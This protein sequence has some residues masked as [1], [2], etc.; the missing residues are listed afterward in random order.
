LA[1]L[2]TIIQIIGKARK[3]NKITKGLYNELMF[4]A[5]KLYKLLEEAE[6]LASPSQELSRDYFDI[7]RKLEGLL[8][9]Q[10]KKDVL[11]TS[12][13]RELAQHKARTKFPANAN[14]IFVETVKLEKF[15]INKNDRPKWIEFCQRS[16]NTPE[17]AQKLSDL[18]GGLVKG[19][20]HQYWINSLFLEAYNHDKSSALTVLKQQYDSTLS[21]TQRILA[22]GK[23]IE[24][25]S[26]EISQWA[27]PKKFKKLYEDF[28]E[29]ILR[30]NYDLQV[31][32]SSNKLAMSISNRSFKNLIDAVDL[33]IKALQTSM[34]YDSSAEEQTQKVH[35]FKRM[36][37]S[38]LK[39]LAVQPET[40]GFRS[41]IQKAKED[42][43]DFPASNEQLQPSARFSVVAANILQ[44]V[45]TGFYRGIA[46][47]KSAA[48]THTL[49][50][51]GLMGALIQR[52]KGDNV[53]HSR[54]PA[55]VSKVEAALL[56]S[57]ALPEFKMPN[58]T[59]PSP[60]MVGSELEFPNLHLHYDLP[61]RNHAGNF[62]IEYD[63]K[64]DKIKLHYTLFGQREERWKNLEF[65]G[66]H[67]F[68]GYTDAQV[69][70]HQCS[71]QGL[72]FELEIDNDVK[73]LPQIMQVI[74]TINLAT[75]DDAYTLLATV[76]DPN[77]EL[78]TKRQNHDIP[79]P[80][81]FLKPDNNYDIDAVDNFL[82]TK[83]ALKEQIKNTI[84]N[85]QGEK[86][87]VL[88]TG[89]AL[90]ALQKGYLNLDLLQNLDSKTISALTSGNVVLAY[91]SGISL[92]TVY[93]LYR[94]G[95]D[96]MLQALFSSSSVQCMKEGFVTLEQLTNT[97]RNGGDSKVALLTSIRQSAG[98]KGAIDAYRNGITFNQ[99]DRAYKTG[100]ASKVS[101]ML[102][103]D[104]E[105][106]GQGLA[107]RNFDEISAIYD[108]GTTGQSKANKLGRLDCAW[109]I[110]D[111][112]TVPELSQALD[113]EKFG[114][115]VFGSGFQSLLKAGI[116]F[117]TL[118]QLWRSDNKKFDDIIGQYNL[119]KGKH[120]FFALIN[121]YD[122]KATFQAVTSANA[123]QLINAGARISELIELYKSNKDKFN[124]FMEHSFDINRSSSFAIFSNLYDIDRP[125]FDSLLNAPYRLYG[126]K[127]SFAALQEMY[128]HN[129]TKYDV[130]ISP[131]LERKL[132]S[133]PLATNH[134]PKE[135][136][137]SS[138]MNL[139]YLSQA[140]DE[141]GEDKLGALT[142]RAATSAYRLSA[143]AQK[144]FKLYDIDLG[145][146][147]SLLDIAARHEDSIINFD[148]MEALYNV[149][150]EELAEKFA[151][152]EAQ[153][154]LREMHI[155][156][157]E[158]L[159]L[160]KEESKEVMTAI[161][162]NNCAEAYKAGAEVED[163][164]KL[165]KTKRQKF[166]ALT[167]NS[168]IWLYES[169]S[170][171]IISFH[172][173]SIKFD[174][175]GKEALAE[176][177]IKSLVGLEI[178]PQMTKAALTDLYGR[179]EDH[180]AFLTT[181]A[182]RDCMKQGVRY[183]ELVS[184]LEKANNT[185]RLQYIVTH[186]RDAIKGQAKLSE[187]L[188]LDN[189]NRQKLETL[190]GYPA[191]DAY[192]RNITFRMLSQAYDEG[193]KEKVE[194]LSNYQN[195]ER[196]KNKEITFEVLS[197]EFD[198]T[199]QSRRGMPSTS[200][201]ILVR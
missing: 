48:D 61:L 122:D 34:Q 144:L 5:N 99:L 67:L 159:R 145:K 89:N 149:G 6:L 77:S 27:D 2:A 201:E 3:Q 170:G 90:L 44:K 179:N 187:L 38:F 112:A 151:N 162:H 35:N 96:K 70:F 80:T 163:L 91:A 182:A 98:G 192:R 168:I 142:S 94:E 139:S 15:L 133:L 195:L 4:T 78:N 129:K 59:L 150:G 25:M 152:N 175:G 17:N 72:K 174:Q 41:R 93:T 103:Y 57:D 141:G 18:I 194:F 81:M 82:K 8:T 53:I 66:L 86:I 26:Q 54:L 113:D 188:G 69:S 199:H 23:E 84:P 116:S 47:H 29:K 88:T 58:S 136:R 1:S 126:D 117:T 19:N 36:I 148:T 100:G 165:F 178:D 137:L 92:D 140:Y 173:L 189:N 105:Y 193:G 16:C 124:F 107:E 28:S 186:G 131:T 87:K 102:K 63:L 197:A 43:A 24:E 62:E 85:N 33:S 39:L 30:L 191:S 14:P 161:A 109:L 108:S 156:G 45:E 71:S 60:Y 83:E 158:L 42:L 115:R 181:Y 164:I 11:S 155:T 76:K 157:E 119:I 51:Q 147:N 13:I 75:L 120:A 123:K 160:C 118:A 65:H 37:K 130:L 9:S 73:T 97:Y 68:S 128:K 32:D 79:D 198:R 138:R 121:I 110:R 171:I 101:E 185:A 184:E 55:I 20:I 196:I 31:S 46:E 183:H 146:F 153:R 172:E 52:S 104:W 169:Y 50:H 74:K 200:R 21:E 154:P 134:G 180:F 7:Y 64:R 166:E 177:S 176:L 143:D 114:Y 125:Q 95:G 10:V 106:F 56:T 132:S 190:I 49:V 167:A 135:V 127:D 111:G 40:K 12:L 22:A